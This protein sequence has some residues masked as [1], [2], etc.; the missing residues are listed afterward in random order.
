[1]DSPYAYAAPVQASLGAPLLAPPLVPAAVATMP[2]PQKK[3]VARPG[4]GPKKPKR[5][6]TAYHFFFDAER[7]AAL[8]AAPDRDKVD[9]NLLSR[10]LGQ[11][12]KAMDANARRRWDE[13]AK[14]A[15]E[16][17]DE[18]VRLF[19]AQGGRM[20]DVTP[21]K[22]LSAYM[23]YF[24]AKHQAQKPDEKVT[25]FAKVTGA[26]WKA[27]SDQDKQ[28][29]HE[30]AKKQR[31][32]YDNQ[33]AF[34]AKSCDQ[35]IGEKFLDG[36]PSV[37]AFARVALFDAGTAAENA[38]EARAAYHVVYDD[39]SRGQETLSLGELKARVCGDERAAK[40]A[41]AR[42]DAAQ[43]KRKA[44]PPP[45]MY[46][47]PVDKKP[48]K[49]PKPPPPPDDEPEPFTDDEILNVLRLTRRVA[50]GANVSNLKKLCAAAGLAN[51]GS[52]AQLASR[53]ERFLREKN[54]ESNPF[55]PSHA[56]NLLP[57]TEFDAKYQAMTVLEISAVEKVVAG[58]L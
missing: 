48:K 52:K 14:G 43:K 40:R 53:L 3:T 34:C 16:D 9:N 41:A 2:A 6:K 1:M 5:P 18:A 12:W 36:R 21:T 38:D 58:L 19:E 22:P 26:E 50:A 10:Q 11:R 29:F 15:K 51:V 27:L 37:M 47:V 55:I 32:L 46:A 39:Q 42:V 13:L 44:I 45:P 24:R 25:D 54:F 31:D 20:H 30:S 49:V 4:T 56:D 33:V 35:L 7:K 23:L 8:D 17:Y 57:F 28:P